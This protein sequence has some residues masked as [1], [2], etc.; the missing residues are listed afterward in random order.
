MHHAVQIQ[1]EIR[2]LREE[3]DRIR[4]ALPNGSSG[5]VDTIGNIT[6]DQQPGRRVTQLHSYD[7]R[8]NFLP[9]NYTI[10][11]LTLASFLAFYL[12]GKPNE[13]VPPF[14]LV[15]P[16]DLKCSNK[17]KKVNE[18]IL[19]DMKKMMEFVEIASKELNVREEDP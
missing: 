16:I 10:P 12:I 18:K 5:S 4:T 9:K 1:G 17:G 15:K 11:S 3:L 8:F 14:R 13:G 7:G 2:G 19:T 6:G